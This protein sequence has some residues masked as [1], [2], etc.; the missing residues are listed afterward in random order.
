MSA[1]RRMRGYSLFKGF[2]YFKIK[3]YTVLKILILDFFS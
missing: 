3:F 1:L 2:I